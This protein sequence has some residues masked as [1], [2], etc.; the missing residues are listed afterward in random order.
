MI[1]SAFSIVGNT[2]ATVPAGLVTRPQ[3]LPEMGHTS[4][5]I[6]S[7][8]DVF[9][10]T[11]QNLRQVPQNVFDSGNRVVMKTNQGYGTNETEVL[12]FVPTMAPIKNGTMNTTITTYNAPNLNLRTLGNAAG[13]MPYGYGRGQVSMNT[14]L[15]EFAPQPLLPVNNKMMFEQVAADKMMVPIPQVKV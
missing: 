10:Q 4:L 12:N 11:N 14:N 1:Q 5:S 3:G 15:A 6:A 13:S 8:Q 7:P 9:T 2:P